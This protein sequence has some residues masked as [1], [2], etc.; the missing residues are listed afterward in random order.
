MPT[1]AGQSGSPLIKTQG[2]NAFAVAIH[3]GRCDKKK[4]NVALKLNEEKRAQI[5][6]WI[7]YPIGSMDLSKDRI[8]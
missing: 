6:K 7:D 4:R 5:N 8:I 3:L 2:K 1:E